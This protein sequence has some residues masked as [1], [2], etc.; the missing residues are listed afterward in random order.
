MCPAFVNS[1]VRP[2]RSNRTW[3]R[4]TNAR[5]SVVRRTSSSRW[6][7][8]VGVSVPPRESAERLARAEAITIPGRE[9]VPRHVGDDDRQARLPLAEEV[10]EVAADRGGG[11][12][13]GRQLDP[14][15]GEV[16]RGEEAPLEVARDRQLA[17]ERLGL[18]PGRHARLEVPGHVVEA[19][20][21]AGELVAPAELLAD[22]EVPL[23]DLG[24]AVREAPG[25]ARDPEDEDRGDEEG[26]EVDDPRGDAERL[27]DCESD[28]AGPLAGARELRL[29]EEAPELR[30]HRRPHEEGGP[31]VLRRRAGL[32][33][34]GREVERQEPEDQPVVARAGLLHA[35]RLS[36]VRVERRDARRL[37]RE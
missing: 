23:L 2:A 8:R 14:G 30:G 32:R 7:R 10:V 15:E 20:H 21:E 13:V 36:L 11:P 22:A 9:P 5:R 25:G 26:E 17:P 19:V 6:A 33:V 24:E 1:A 37:S 29:S 12:E 28:G 18:G 31:L 4:V 35:A 3:A 34:E 16:G 27:E